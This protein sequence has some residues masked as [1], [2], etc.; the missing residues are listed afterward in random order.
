MGYPTGDILGADGCFGSWAADFSPPEPSRATMPVTTGSAPVTKTIGIV[1]V[2]RRTAAVA[3]S[4]SVT[5]MSGCRPTN[6]KSPGAM[7]GEAE[8]ASGKPGERRRHIH[9]APGPHLTSTHSPL[10]PFRRRS[11]RRASFVASRRKR[12]VDRSC[13]IRRQWPGC[14]ARWSPSRRRSGG[15]HDARVR[16][17]APGPPIGPLPRPPGARQTGEGGQCPLTD[18]NNCL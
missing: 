8:C 11:L 15:A 17:S 1:R 5:M 4:P 18:T 14:S 3:G 16:R 10:R 9:A 6:S 13:R 2:S 12:K 7:L